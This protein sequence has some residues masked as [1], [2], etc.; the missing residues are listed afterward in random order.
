MIYTPVLTPALDTAAG[1]KRRCTQL[2]GIEKKGS[3]YLFDFSLLKRWL[4]ICRKNKIEYIE[5]SH[6]FSQW[7]LEYSPNIE[8]TENG[9]SSCMFGWNVKATDPSYKDFLEQ[10]LP[11]LIDF[12]RDEEVL[13]KCYF[14]ISDEPSQNHIGAY[15]YAH[16]IVVP[17][18][19]GCKV[20]EA[21]SNIDFYEMEL[22]NIPVTATSHIEPFLEKHI[23][24][25]W[26][27]YCCAQSDKV[28]NRFL[29]MP[30]YINRILGLQL[31]KYDIEGFL[32]GGYNFYNSGFSLYEINPYITTSADKTFPSGDSFSVY[33]GKDG[34]PPS[35]RAFVFKDALQDI[36]ICR[37]LEKQI[38]KEAV[39][40]LM[41]EE[42]GMETTFS[43]YPRDNEFVPK[44]IEKMKNIIC[45]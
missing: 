17:M 39:I 33:P 30:S 29:S 4:S 35:M 25:Q 21:L 18:L 23:K 13:D 16:D 45:S 42:A 32:Q 5:I 12:L 44:L 22:V 11:Q 26:A 24:H 9:E 43:Q 38:G 3:E 15:R 31:Y 1:V 6:L 41:E 8:V 7:S 19:K 20:I 27:Y 10:F 40:K 36:S 14:H 28:G 37:M 2:V 34:P